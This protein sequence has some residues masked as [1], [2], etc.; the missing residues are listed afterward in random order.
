MSTTE[1][2]FEKK[3]RELELRND[4]AMQG[5]GA[6]KLAKHK[7]GGRLT[8][9][10]RL[11]I[12]LDPGSFNEMD[13]FVT[14][15][16]TNYGMAEQKVPGDGVVTGHGRVNGKLVYVSSQDFTVIGG[17]MSRTQANKICKVMDLALKNGAPFISLNDS[18]GA[19][20]QE[21]IESLGGYADS[22]SADHSNPW[23]LRW[24]SCLFS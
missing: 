16:C 19:R 3:L 22:D 6:A 21:G 9:R 24:R 23:T 15:R 10:E 12:L 14:H 1:T 5:G 4:R 8:A 2:L 20:I 11:D 7:Q 17:S 13:R 18:G